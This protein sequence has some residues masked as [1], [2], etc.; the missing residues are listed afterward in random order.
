[1]TPKDKEGSHK[2]NEN[3]T[4]LANRESETNNS[5]VLSNHAT[6][7]NSGMV[8]AKGMDS[9][10]NQMAKG[11]RDPNMQEPHDKNQSRDSGAKMVSHEFSR[12]SEAENALASAK[13]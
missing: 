3:F 5:I 4:Q 2:D 10:Q 8:A 9:T 12:R 7:A 1:L 13:I 11:L 6:I